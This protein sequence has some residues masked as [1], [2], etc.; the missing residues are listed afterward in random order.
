MD[1]VLHNS[2]LPYKN[3]KG[4]EDSC[5]MIE[6]INWKDG[7]VSLQ[8]AKN[9]K[10]EINFRINKLENDKVNFG[11][12][13]YRGNNVFV[14]AEKNFS[15]LFFKTKKIRTFNFIFY[16]TGT[17]ITERELYQHVLHYKFSNGLFSEELPPPIA[18]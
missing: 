14:T 7:S 17:N 10:A 15:P 18:Q 16:S 8:M 12:F 2:N 13:N 5:W 9:S 6:L 4:Q 3:E 1:T 11:C